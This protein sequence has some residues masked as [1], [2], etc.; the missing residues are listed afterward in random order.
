MDN[1]DEN[2]RDTTF[3]DGAISQLLSLETNR[4]LNQAQTLL[5]TGLLKVYCNSVLIEYKI[6]GDQFCYRFKNRIDGSLQESEILSPELGADKLE[7]LKIIFAQSEA[8]AS[9]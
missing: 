9:L 6:S 2:N 8:E 5:E 1:A 4:Y 7:A 3:L